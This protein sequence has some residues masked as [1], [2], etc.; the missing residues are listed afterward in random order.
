MI[1]RNGKFSGKILRTIFWKIFRTGKFSME[2]FPPHITKD[3]W[4]GVWRQ[5]PVWN[6]RVSK[7][8]RFHFPRFIGLHVH[9]LQI[10]IS[11]LKAHQL[12]ARTAM[13]GAPCF[14]KCATYRKNIWNATCESRSDRQF[15]SRS[16]VS[17]FYGEQFLRKFISPL[18]YFFVPQLPAG[19]I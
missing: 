2:N 8:V 6:K 13:L 11:C 19:P 9:F 18:R 14:V 15:M 10:Q 7:C 4:T 16:C 5:A 1:L 3:I 12:T 17:S